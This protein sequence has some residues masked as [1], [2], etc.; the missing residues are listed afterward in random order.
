[1]T[2]ALLKKKRV[3]AEPTSSGQLSGGGPD[4]KFFL[5]SDSSPGR[6]WSRCV[7]DCPLGSERD[8][9]ASGRRL[10]KRNRIEGAHNELFRPGSDEV[11]G[12]F[13]T[14]EHCQR[15]KELSKDRWSPPQDCNSP[16]VPPRSHPRGDGASLITTGAL[17]SSAAWRWSRKTPQPLMPSTAALVFERPAAVKEAPSLSPAQLGGSRPLDS[18]HSYTSS[19]TRPRAMLQEFAVDFQPPQKAAGGEQTLQREQTS[20]RSSSTRRVAEIEGEASPLV[21][22]WNSES[23]ALRGISTSVPGGLANH[24]VWDP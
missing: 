13:R 5:A 21:F 2:T 20:S 15:E 19:T 6:D 12:P 9:L 17:R 10:V 18:R 11:S 1:M 3:D 14:L 24:I 8:C 7:S 22:V 16:Q 4:D 23:Q